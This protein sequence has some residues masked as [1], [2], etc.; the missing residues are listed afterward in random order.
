MKYLKLKLDSSNILCGIVYSVYNGLM[1]IN[2][3]CIP[4]EIRSVNKL[5]LLDTPCS[6][7]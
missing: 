5:Y 6:A 4:R 7:Y 3:I 1:S 2:N